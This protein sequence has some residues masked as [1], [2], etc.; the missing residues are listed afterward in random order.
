MTIDPQLLRAE[1]HIEVGALLQRDAGI[2]IERWCRRAM[3]EQP[4]AR[5]V[6]QE[7]LRDQLADLL[8]ALGQTLAD[9]DDGEASPHRAPAIEHGEQRW[10][11]GWSLPEVVR[12]YQ[13]LR[14][15][16]LDY[17][18]EALERPLLAREVMAIGL[19]LDEAIIASVGMYVSNREEYI[20][21]VECDR[22]DRARQAEEAINKWEHLFRH[23]GWGMAI[24]GPKDDTLKAVNPAFAEMHGQDVSTLVGHPLAES[25]APEFR[26]ELPDYLRIAD[27]QGRQVYEAEHLRK[28]GTRFPVLTNLT[29]FKDPQG[30]VLFR[31]A[32]FQDIS[33][34]KLFEDKL[35]RQTAILQESERRKDE[36]LAT[37]GHE[38]RN[39]LAP[40]A[41]SVEA[42]RL[43]DTRHPT[44]QQA[45]EIVERQVKQMARVVDDLL[46]VSRIARGQIVLRRDRL[47]LAMIA[48]L[49]VQTSEAFIKPRNHQ[50]SVSLPTEPLWLVGDSARL[51]QV[52]TNLLNNAA[53][54][55]DPGGHIWL[56]GAREGMEVVLRV[57][58]NGMGI[59][60]DMLGR[61][62]D[63]F[64]QLEPANRS[65][66][67]LGIGLAL[68]R[69]LVNLHGGTITAYSAGPGQ[70]S[71]L[72]VRLP[73]SEEPHAQDS[74]DPAAA[75][76][77][78][79]RR[80]LVVEDN[81]DGLETMKTLLKLWGHCVEVAHNGQE[82]I[83]KL[84]A[85]R[86]EIALIDIGLPVLDGFEVARRAREACGKNVC[87]I[88]LTGYGHED[89]RRRALQA[90]FDAHL[91]KPVDPAEL[92]RL[93][94]QPG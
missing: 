46:D 22:R 87:L 18:Q 47:E 28:N 59:P 76:A 2:L 36:F 43:A 12:D 69:R 7:A 84:L 49:A 4:N 77:G 63:P 52:L 13:I 74:A 67:G 66:G 35:R 19:A 24:I 78:A 14:L 29:A 85:L 64:T 62:F 11:A 60:P 55:T 38:L 6:H 9:C 81:P 41:N 88:A 54:Y 16:I 17:L 94:A 51:V 32:T 56:S 83:D 50:L 40:I 73:L 39:F 92:S 42:L 79:S 68:A 80:V 26:K 27:E 15:V 53:K 23:A 70:G 72:V 1:R 37:L 75:P 91:I 34:R 82:G 3:E 61:I 58:D 20:L 21:Q 45:R 44:V 90:G 86:P 89:D 25:F 8:W 30:K 33:E 71:E 48:A 10:E 31:A 65:Q 93:L 57:R 5:R